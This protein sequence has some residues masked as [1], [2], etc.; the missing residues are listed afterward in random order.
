MSLRERFPIFQKKVYLNSCSQGALSLDVQEAYA[1]YLCDWEEQGSPWELWVERLEAV[2]QA[3][4]AL[5]NAEPD[6]VA[7]QALKLGAQK[8]PVQTKTVTR[9][10]YVAPIK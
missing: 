2:R 4:S 3:F 8:L 1:R 10:D 5:V 9:V 7:V 6:E